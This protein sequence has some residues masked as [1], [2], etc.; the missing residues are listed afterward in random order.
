M[1]QYQPMRRIAIFILLCVITAAA[2]QSTEITSALVEARLRALRLRPNLTEE[3]LNQVSEVYRATLDQIRLREDW[4]K[5]AEQL[6]AELEDRQQPSSAADEPKLEYPQDATSEQLHQLYEQAA[7]SLNIARDELA[8]TEQRLKD[9]AERRKALPE[10]V[11]EAKLRLDRTSKERIEAAYPELDAARQMLRKATIQALTSEVQYYESEL[12][13]APLREKFLTAEREMAARKLSQLERLNAQWQALLTSYTRS[14][15]ERMLQIA[16]RDLEQVASNPVLKRLAEQNLALAQA[17]V[18]RFNT[19]AKIDLTQ[20]ELDST[21]QKLAQ[22]QESFTRLRSRI[23]AIGLTDSTG[24]LLRKTM[25]ELPDAREYRR[26][27][28]SRQQELSSTQLQILEL[29][30]EQTRS[31]KLEE[32]LRVELEGELQESLKKLLETRALLLKTQ[33]A[34]LNRYF[35]LIM[36]LDIE[37]KRLVDEIGRNRIFIE[38]NILWVKTLPTFS[39]WDLPNSFTFLKSR[40]NLGFVRSNLATFAENLQRNLFRSIL[41]VVCALLAIYTLHHMRLKLRGY[42]SQIGVLEAAQPGIDDIHGTIKVFFSTILLSTF[43]PAMVLILWTVLD[44]VGESSVLV[45]ALATGLQTIIIPY[46]TTRFL[47]AFTMPMGLAQAHLEWSSERVSTLRALMRIVN[48]LVLPTAFLVSFLQALN[49]VEREQAVASRIAY[50]L[51]QLVLAYVIF[52]LSHPARGVVYEEQD[53]Q[54]YWLRTLICTVASFTP[55]LLALFSAMGYYYAATHL[56]SLF[57]KTVLALSYLITLKAVAYSLVIARAVRQG[58]EASAEDQK[59]LE[60]VK[61]QAY[62]MISHGSTIIFMLFLL[63]IWTPVVPALTYLNRVELWAT[64]VEVVKQVTGED[65][66]AVSRVVDERVSIKLTD[67]IICLMIVLITLVTARNVPGFIEI[68]FLQRLPFDAGARYAFTV[69]SRYIIVTTGLFLSAGRLGIKWGH[70][71]WMI[72]AISVGLGFGLQ[73]IF[74]NFISGLIIL[75]ERPVR[76]GDIVT[77]GETTGTVS[78]I[79]IRSTTIT[80]YDM[81]ELIIPNKNFITGQVI[82]WTLSTTVSR[83]T[84]PVQVA[85]NTDTALVFQLLQQAVEAVPV[86]LKE[87]APV[88]LFT[89]FGQDGLD[90]KLFFYIPTRDV[91]VE[92]LSQVNEQIYSLF[93]QKGISIPYP[94]RD[95]HIRSIGGDS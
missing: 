18:S 54:R 47:L 12:L 53:E 78:R 51:S 58:E 56:S 63:F 79:R 77:V 94:Q 10:I 60:Q 29:E 81:K 89:G 35:D 14:E 93:N 72:A 61:L 92:A 15:A 25:E 16:N 62:R 46:L 37:Q 88:V 42:I 75:F 84:V 9:L 23:A 19:L 67:L 32:S 20:T 65:G 8:A 48:T 85:Y 2:Q 45:N 86:V 39:L 83:V 28:S 21:R 82:N 43:R 66:K 7:N 22:L 26:Y 5:Q 41:L 11:A 59:S 13:A 68:V 55:L 3:Q 57:G 6:K 80:D 95:V 90:F 24:V 40:I 71:Q 44:Y 33:I 52:R 76:V 64:S 31:L 1:A 27:I 4:I 17:R 69:V 30:E 36:E 87:P 49:M 34:E 91:Y 70:V 73:E 38:E 74:S 50:I